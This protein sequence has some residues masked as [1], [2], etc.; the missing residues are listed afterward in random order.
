MS[1][2]FEANEA[3]TTEPHPVAL[4]DIGA[5]SVRMAIAELQASG[6]GRIL[7]SLTQAV[8]LGKD[9][10]IKGRL[11]RATIEDCV[12]VLKIY[13]HKLQE[14]QI[15]RREDIRVVA[16][17]AVREASNRLAFLDRV[18]VATGLEVEPFDEA[19]LHRVT[20][21]AI[22]PYLKRVP[23]L[24]SQPVVVCEI[25]GG[26]TEV[27]GIQQETIQYSRTYRMGSLRLRRTL[28]KFNAP[29]AR[30]REIMERE[31]DKTAHK[32]EHEVGAE[33]QVQFVVM[34]GDV[35]LLAS[36]L[37]PD[38]DPESPVRLS[39]NE[40]EPFVDELSKLSV[41]AVS[42]KHYLSLPEAES[43][44][45]ALLAYVHIAKALKVNH[46]WVAT[47]TL[48]E[49]LLREMSQ[50]RRRTAAFT[51]QII[52]SAL[53]LG[54]RFNIDESHARHVADV[55]RAIFKQL[56][57]EHKLDHRFEVVLYL[58][59]LLHEVGLSINHRSFHKHSLYILRNSE[60]FGI[61]KRELLL[62][63]MV[64][65]YHRRASPSPL[66]DVYGSLTR[67][68]RV[69]VSKMAAL[70][71]IAKAIDDSRLQRIHM[72]ECE[73]LPDIVV[74]HIPGVEDLA[75]E[76]IALSQQQNLFEEVYGK[77]VIL[78]SKR[79]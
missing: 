27:L 48:R 34:G 66:H 60:I 19:Q 51:N 30:F 58:A 39:L 14:Y 37:R 57:S 1:D 65:R 11:D 8:S 22:E 56:K 13:C 28:E 15:H 61:S 76:K 23:E 25:G 10:F 75:L 38:Q 49:G 54:R 41:V 44:T 77:R 63:A 53:D 46:L 72:F 17:S 50:S 9:S 40:I 20:Y 79:V 7:E 68:E 62:V 26:S 70:L 73:I 42:R 16:T 18:Y 78:R 59:A 47:P 4:I 31:I 24:A 55:V 67:E 36:K 2:N 32:I 29:A 5:T 64:A 69:A 33:S 45:T 52:Q 35:R 21:L 71:R 74:I 12:R 3:V 43:L 6:D